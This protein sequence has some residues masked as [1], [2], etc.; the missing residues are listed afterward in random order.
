M[1]SEQSIYS[2]HRA[3][4]QESKR[5]RE[6]ESKR[7]REQESDNHIKGDLPLVAAPSWGE[8]VGGRLEVRNAFLPQLRLVKG[9]GFLALVRP[10]GF[11]LQ[12]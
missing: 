1:N 12:F 4:E 7:A 9:R 11:G 3:R 2:L 6:Q 8:G 10:G 5:T